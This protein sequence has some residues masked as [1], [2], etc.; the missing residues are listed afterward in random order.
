[1]SGPGRRAPGWVRRRPDHQ[2][3]PPQAV[4]VC[5]TGRA[6][7]SAGTAPAA[8]ELHS[9]AA[10]APAVAPADAENRRAAGAG[11]EPIAC[12]RAH[13]AGRRSDGEATHVAATA[14]FLCGTWPQGERGGVVSSAAGAA[15]APHA[16]ARAAAPSCALA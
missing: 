6:G 14:A 16:D 12:A 11:A 15:A 8:Q 4:S 7:G 9:T 10:G 13:R 3:D 5:G 2:A 1:G